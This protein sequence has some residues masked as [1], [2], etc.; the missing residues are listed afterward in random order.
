M[1]LESFGA[2]DI[3]LVR[4]N[5]EDVWAQMPK[6]RFFVLADG[7][8]GHNAGEIAANETVRLLCDYV[9]EAHKNPHTT[10]EWL[11]IL[12][13]GVQKV[14]TSIFQLALKNKAL[15]GMGTTLCFILIQNSSLIYGHVG[16]SRIYRLRKGRLTQLTHDHSLKGELIAKGKLDES[17]AASF[18]KNVITRAIGT[19]PTVTPDIDFLPIELGDLYFLCSDG[20]TDVLSNAQIQEILEESSNIQTASKNLILAANQKGGID[21]ITILI[22][23]I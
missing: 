23:K 5:N 13:Q 19:A 10:Q 9:K 7:M 1:K 2:T 20:L 4:L 12:D 15:E 14:N 16:D 21:N 22:I 3:G 11:D 18:P 6:E 17:R 8:G